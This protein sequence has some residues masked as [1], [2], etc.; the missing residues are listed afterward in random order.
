MNP[1]SPIL[2]SLSEGSGH[3]SELCRIR[4][5]VAFLNT[6]TRHLSGTLPSHLRQNTRVVYAQAGR[7]T[8]ESAGMRQQM[9]LLLIIPAILKKMRTHMPELQNIEIIIC[10]SNFPAPPS[11]V[12]ERTLSAESAGMIEC[13]A[14]LAPPELRIALERLAR[15]HKK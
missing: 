8:L 13:V 6:L 1:Y 10:R 2:S 5:Y 14:T 9:E 3:Q 4:D 12:P 11:P 15:C 7:L